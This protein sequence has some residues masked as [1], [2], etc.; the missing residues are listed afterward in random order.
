MTYYEYYPGICKWNGVCSKIAYVPIDP[1]NRQNIHGNFRK[2]MCLDYLFNGTIRMEMKKPMNK[3]NAFLWRFSDYLLKVI[4]SGFNYREKEKQRQQQQKKNTEQRT[5][6]AGTQL[7]ARG[8]KINRSTWNYI[9]E[10]RRWNPDGSILKREKKHSHTHTHEKHDKII[11]KAYLVENSTLKRN[12]NRKVLNEFLKII[13]KFSAN[14]TLRIHTM[15]H[16]SLSVWNVN[17]KPRAL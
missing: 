4:G 17:R 11:W 8:T 16:R 3:L 13:T 9:C 15:L 6:M 7:N 10:H 14:G 1:T 2:S 5:E 12:E